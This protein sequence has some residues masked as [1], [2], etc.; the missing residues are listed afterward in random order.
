MPKTSKSEMAKWSR[1]TAKIAALAFNLWQQCVRGL[2]C[3]LWSLQ[4]WC[5]HW[6]SSYSHSL[7]ISM[8]HFPPCL[9]ECMS[10]FLHPPA[11]FQFNHCHPYVIVFKMACH[12][13]VNIMINLFCICYGENAV[14]KCLSLLQVQGAW[15][16]S[17]WNRPLTVAFLYN[18]SHEWR[19]KFDLPFKCQM[20][21]RVKSKIIN[22]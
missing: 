1:M 8:V 7:N 9:L 12:V 4:S 19:H 14:G 10:H 21:S 22:L 6:Q 11:T 20:Q 18:T 3:L 13:F 15:L 5:L 17:V 16:V 2:I